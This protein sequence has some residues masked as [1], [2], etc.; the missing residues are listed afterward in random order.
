MHCE[1]PLQ[2]RASSTKKNIKGKQSSQKKLGQPQIFVLTG[3]PPSTKDPQPRCAL[4]KSSQG[5]TCL[6]IDPQQDID[7]G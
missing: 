3:K 1:T 7:T 2:L 5:G 4:Q 6:E